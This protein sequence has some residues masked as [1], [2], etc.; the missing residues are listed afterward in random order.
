VV[1]F[2]SQNTPQIRGQ[3]IDKR[4][5]QPLGKLQITGKSPAIADASCKRAHL[6][7]IDVTPALISLDFLR[8]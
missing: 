5:D 1:I 4:Q 2:T 6:D 7:S 3:P 8:R